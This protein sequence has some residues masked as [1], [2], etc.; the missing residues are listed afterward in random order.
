MGCLKVSLLSAFG[1]AIIHYFNYL[2]RFKGDN[3]AYLRH[4]GVRI[5]DH[6]Q[7][8]NSINDFGTEPYLIEIGGGITITPRVILLTHDG[9][10]RLFRKTEIGMNAKYG[11]RFG[12]IRIGENCFIGIHSIIMPGVSI[13]DNS[14]VGA[15]SV[16]SH[17]VP[18]NM[19]VA[20]NPAKLICTLEEY[21]ERYRKKMLTL[22]SNNRSDL[23]E[24]LTQKLWGSQR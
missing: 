18:P 16:V 4:L 17:D 2:V 13:G 23:R 10:S 8:N 14:I 9:S 7:I 20:G 24:E 11:N 12:T 19:V 15:G 5:G 21:K 3:V 22:V 6:C 1:P